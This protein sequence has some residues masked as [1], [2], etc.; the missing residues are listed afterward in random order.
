MQ[1]LL[2]EYSKAL[3]AL[4]QPMVARFAP[5]ADADTLSKVDARLNCV[6]PCTLRRFYLTANGQLSADGYT[7]SG[8]CIIPRIRYDLED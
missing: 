7:P 2:D 3:W 8:D 4:P 1:A 6:I 5:P